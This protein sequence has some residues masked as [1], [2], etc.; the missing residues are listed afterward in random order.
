MIKTMIVEMKNT[1]K[2]KEEIRA[3]KEEIKNRE[4]E[5]KEEKNELVKKI[6]ALENKMEKEDYPLTRTSA[7]IKMFSMIPYNCHNK[8]EVFNNVTIGDLT[9]S[10]KL[11]VP[12][13]ATAAT[14]IPQGAVTSPI[15]PRLLTGNSDIVQILV[16]IKTDGHLELDHSSKQ[17]WSNNV[18]W[19]R[20]IRLSDDCHSSNIQLKLQP[21]NKRCASSKLILEAVRPISVGQEL[22]LWFSEEVLALMQMVFLTPANIQGQKR[23]VCTKCSALYESP[24]P[25][26]LHL[27][28]RCGRQSI[29]DLWQRLSHL[30]TEN[31]AYTNTFQAAFNE[32][33]FKLTPNVPFIKQKN[34]MDLSAT[35]EPKR[36]VSHPSKLTDLKNSD[37]TRTLYRPYSEPPPTH[38][39]A[40]KP[41]QKT[42]VTDTLNNKILSSNMQYWSNVSIDPQLYVN[43]YVNM[44]TVPNDESQMES[45]VSNLG[46]SKDGHICLYCGKCYSRK[47]GLKIHIRTHTGY[48]PLKCKFCLRPFGDPSNLNKHVRLHAEGDTPYKC[49]LCGKILVRRRDLERH[50]KS[51][52]MSEIHPGRGI[53]NEGN[54]TSETEV[55]DDDTQEL[56]SNI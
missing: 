30:L 54:N 17:V 28:L 20:A 33:T 35:T 18:H 41:F 23:Y 6:E 40:F 44:N 16:G 27:L 12:G 19:I 34:A 3:F 51:R 9:G 2:L 22:L 48:K 37:S 47:Y 4:E 31:N 49:D 25:L 29:S 14:N 56:T 53:G 52:H 1:T 42:T 15:E 50:L 32:F 13:R 21:H 36:P 5:W 45:I 11:L 38:N 46:K 39:S 26:K 10:A 55:T 8:Y 7:L 43:H 24:N